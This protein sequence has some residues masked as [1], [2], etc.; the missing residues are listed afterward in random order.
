MSQGLD[1]CALADEGRLV[2]LLRL[3]FFDAKTDRS[4]PQWRTQEIEARP[5]TCPYGLAGPCLGACPVMPAWMFAGCPTVPVIQCPDM[6]GDLPC[7][8]GT[9]ARSCPLSPARPACHG[10]RLAS[11]VSGQAGHLE[12]GPV[13]VCPPDL[14]LRP[15]GRHQSLPGHVRSEPF[16][17]PWT[18]PVMP[19]CA[20]ESCRFRCPD[21]PVIRLR[22]RFRC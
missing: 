5:R 9:R 21:M 16:L 22:S 13:R 20:P 2:P 1:T 6:P 4:C 8:P 18:R 10:A 17:L 12:H 3:L 14:S 19:V 11:C 15:G 7:P